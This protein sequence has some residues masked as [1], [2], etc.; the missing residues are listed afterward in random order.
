MADKKI[1]TRII[2]KHD[3]KANWDKAVNFVPLKGEIIIYTDENKVKIG[4]GETTVINLPYATASDAS[5]VT[6]GT[7]S[8]GTFTF[9]NS[10]NEQIF[11]IDLPIYNGEEL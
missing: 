1:Q 9:K 7:F 10:K 6:S 5:V 8:N 3:T 4:D 11:T 2:N